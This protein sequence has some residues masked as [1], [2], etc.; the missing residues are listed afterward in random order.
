MVL[1]L[2]HVGNTYQLVIKTSGKEKNWICARCSAKMISPMHRHNCHATYDTFTQRD[3]G[4]GHRFR[5]KELGSTLQRCDREMRK[6]YL[7]HNVEPTQHKC[8]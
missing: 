4:C 3:F 7:W 2:N 8:Y 6:I 1:L 5:T